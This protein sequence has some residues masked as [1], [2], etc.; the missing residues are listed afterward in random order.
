[1]TS[2]VIYFLVVL[3]A[4]QYAEVKGL[5]SRGLADD[6]LNQLMAQAEEL[7]KLIDSAAS[8][9]QDAINSANDQASQIIN[10]TTQNME[11][12]VQNA[13]D[14]IN[15]YVAEAEQAGKDVS[16][17]LAGQF[18]ALDNIVSQAVPDLINCTQAQIANL[19]YILQDINS[20]K[21]QVLAIIKE[22]PGGLANC[23]INPVCLFNYFTTTAA[24]LTLLTASV[25][26]DL[27][28]LA[29]YTAELGAKLAQCA[30]VELAKVTSE[31]KDIVSNT[32]ACILN[33]RASS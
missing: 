10:S 22:I 7:V 31:I 8:Q 27:V 11:Q 14:E 2:K 33:T 26:D 19:V 18:E 30:T 16:G 3:C 6:Y 1:M 23:S 24:K 32:I 25:N 5:Q 4:F 15:S 29:T 12:L 28:K 17:C 20:L 13:K 9:V 21:Q